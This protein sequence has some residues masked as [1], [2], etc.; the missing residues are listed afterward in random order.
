MNCEGN[1]SQ[2]KHH[3]INVWQLYEDTKMYSTKTGKHI[4][5]LEYTK[6]RN[7][8]DVYLV[9]NFFSNHAYSHNIDDN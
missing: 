2:P 3:K 6:G 1:L 9:L 7:Y 5:D 4:D 8:I